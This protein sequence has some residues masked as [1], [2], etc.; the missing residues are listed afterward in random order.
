M[1]KAEANAGV[2]PLRAAAETTGAPSAVRVGKWRR[3]KWVLRAVNCDGAAY[4]V[5]VQGAGMKIVSYEDVPELCDQILLDAGLKGET[6]EGAR[7]AGL[8]PELSRWT[9]DRGRVSSQARTM[10]DKDT[11]SW[12]RLAKLGKPG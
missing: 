9:S 6:F 1:T 2:T 8:W 5:T 4:T 10:K 7:V 12:V 11:Q 3:R